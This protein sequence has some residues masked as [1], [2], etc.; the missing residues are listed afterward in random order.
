MKRLVDTRQGGQTIALY[1][2]TMLALALITLFSVSVGV[3]VRDKIKAQATADATAYGLAVSQAR[4]MN[5]MAWANRAMVSEYVSALSVVGHESY[6][7][8]WEGTLKAQS[9]QMSGPE[10]VYGIQCAFCNPYCSCCCQAC[11]S[12]NQARK[13]KNMWKDKYDQVHKIWHVNG[14]SLHTALHMLDV[15]YVVGAVQNF[16]AG[17]TAFTDYQ[18]MAANQTF[19]DKSAKAIDDRMR[20][21]SP[22]RSGSPSAQGNKTNFTDAVETDPVKED[23]DSYH[24]IL[25]GTRTDWILKHSNFV[26]GLPWMEGFMEQM[27][28]AAS[29]DGIAISPM[30]SNSGGAMVTKENSVSQVVQVNTG[31]AHQYNSGAAKGEGGRVGL[32]AIN[33]GGTSV[34]MICEACEPVSYG[35]R[36]ESYESNTRYEG[37]KGCHND[38]FSAAYDGYGD[39]DTSGPSQNIQ[40]TW[41]SANGVA[42]LGGACAD[43]GITAGGFFRFKLDKDQKMDKQSAQQILWNQPYTFSTI[44]LDESSGQKQ[45]WDISYGKIGGSLLTNEAGTD[46][47]GN[48]NKADAQ[49]NLASMGYDST[50][51]PQLGAFSAG[52]TYYHNPD[53]WAEVPN[54]WNPFWRAKLEDPTGSPDANGQDTK[55]PA[56]NTSQVLS[57]DDLKVANAMGIK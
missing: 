46:A 21:S 44:E 12:L 11:Q 41:P 4:A 9:D 22:S 48:Q 38:S 56:P 5:V 28:D 24:E 3:R 54:L 43:Q 57:G 55:K 47:Y 19:A 45:A 31:T 36:S 23:W 18:N 13:I 34:L 33:K 1:A 20:A 6:L 2:I 39:K 49:H 15:A 51:W 42:Q 50:V 17:K 32:S 35:S 8:Y 37:P 53:H 40:Y 26:P 52:L 14:Q 16:Q 27:E 10:A 29:C 25:T 30:P 7:Q